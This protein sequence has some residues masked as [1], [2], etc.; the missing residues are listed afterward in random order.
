MNNQLKAL[1]IST[2]VYPFAKTGGLV[3]VSAFLP[4]S[5]RALSYDVR[6]MMP[7]FKPS[8]KG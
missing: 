2:E 8:K 3:D 4:K 1:Y 6:I 5:L 7:K